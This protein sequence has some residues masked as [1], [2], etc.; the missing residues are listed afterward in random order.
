MIVWGGKNS[1]G[2]LADGG[3]YDPFADRWRPIS[4]T[5][6]PSARS[7]ADGV[8]TGCEMIVWG[9]SLLTDGGIY[10]PA[11]DSWRPLD[12]SGAPT[13]RVEPAVQWT[14]TEMAV[15]GGRNWTVA[16]NLG[17]LDTGFLFNPVTNR[18]RPMGRMGVPE[19]R[20]DSGSAFTG[21]A[22][23][24][25]GG[26]FNFRVHTRGNLIPSGGVYDV[27]SGTWSAISEAGAPLGRWS[28][29][30]TRIAI[31]T[32]CSFVVWGGTTNDG[33]SS[34]V[35]NTGGIWTPSL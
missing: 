10:N 15:W 33:A 20:T 19:G 4:A 21:N 34:G 2:D 29:E 26:E 23:I 31:W 18:W 9:G 1:S 3:I 32:G 17:Y 30:R 13:S 5:N 27:A 12:T 8:W 16:E 24:V 11:N 35:S 14:G 6:A 22:M 28:G 25:W 7:D